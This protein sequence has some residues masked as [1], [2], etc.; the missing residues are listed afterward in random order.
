MSIPGAEPADDSVITP[1]SV[2]S[3]ELKAIGISLN[4][5]LKRLYAILKL[6][7]VKME[8]STRET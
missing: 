4:I 3:S 5:F 2:K 7:V 1:S 8:S 6:R